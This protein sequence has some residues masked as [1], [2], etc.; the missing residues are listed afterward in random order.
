MVSIVKSVWEKER[1]FFCSCN[2]F[3]VIVLVMFVSERILFV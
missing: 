3:I 1:R 2:V